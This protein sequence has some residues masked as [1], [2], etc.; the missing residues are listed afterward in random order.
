MELKASLGVRELIDRLIAKQSCRVLHGISRGGDGKNRIISLFILCLLLTAAFGQNTPK[1]KL[2]SV[3]ERAERGEAI[4]Q[5]MLAQ[6]YSR[7]DGVERDIIEATGWYRKAAEGG[8]ILSE[9]IIAME[10][11]EGNGGLERNLEEA[12][13]W[14]RRAAEHGD[15]AAQTLLAS[16]Y[17][18]GHGAS[19][20]YAEAARWYSDAGRQGVSLSPS[21]Q[22]NIGWLF[23]NGTG[24][25]PQDQSKGTYWFRRAADQGDPEGQ[26]LLGRMYFDG[27]GAVQDYTQC[28]MWMNLSASKSNGDDRKKAAE[29]RDMVAMLMTREQVVKA[30]QM[31]SEWTPKKGKSV[32]DFL[33]DL[34]RK[35]LNTEPPIGAEAK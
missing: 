9:D 27:D 3:R 7:G 1:S 2:A 20:D 28:H 31:A 11:D 32:K 4:A 12:T 10:Y 29:F 5:L 18:Y 35:E 13:K 24:G 8:D 30:Q 26:Y 17:Y 23:I 16:R 34:Y 15:V 6:M 22:I 19:Q 25:V 14:Y 33:D 21:T